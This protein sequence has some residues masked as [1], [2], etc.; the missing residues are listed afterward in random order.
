MKYIVHTRTEDPD[1]KAI[2]TDIV[3]NGIPPDAEII[4]DERNRLFR[5]HIKGIP[6]IVK[7]F[8]R[9]NAVNSV[10]YVT[11]RKS[12]ARRSFENAMRLHA[13]GIATPMPEAYMEVRSHMHLHQSYYICRDVASPQIRFWER[14]PDAASLEQAFAADII[15]LHTLGVWHKDFSPG[16]ILVQHSEADGYTFYY[17]DLNRMKFNVHTPGRLLGMFGRLHDNEAPIRSLARAY[18]HILTQNPSLT[19]PGIN[20]AEVESAALQAH[21]RFWAKHA[22]RQ[23]LKQKIRHKK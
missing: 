6:Y 11:I 16:N 3:R 20:P 9:P 14:R 10:A 1:L 15:R 2:A 13:L 5:I 8:R 4:Y 12:K 17:I 22:R 19:P 21:R 18:T 23:A 7:A